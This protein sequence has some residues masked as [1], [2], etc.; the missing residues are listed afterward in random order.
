METGLVQIYENKGK[1][2]F[3]REYID[4]EK[5]REFTTL[6]GSKTDD[7]LQLV[8]AKDLKRYKDGKKA[9]RKFLKGDITAFSAMIENQVR[10][11]NRDIK[12][13]QNLITP[14]ENIMLV[15]NGKRFTLTEKNLKGGV[16]EALKNL[17]FSGS[18]VQEGKEKSDAIEVEI[19]NGIANGSIEILERPTK[20]YD[21]KNAGFFKYLNTTD[22]DLTRYQIIKNETEKEHIQ[23]HCLIHTLLLCGIPQDICNAIML[24]FNS[25]YDFPKSKLLKVTE[26]IK[27]NIHLYQARDEQDKK[28]N[29]FSDS[30]YGKYDNEIKI[31]IYQKHYFI[32]EEVDYSIFSIKNYK[33]VKNERFFNK[34]TSKRTPQTYKREKYNKINS[35]QLIY[36]LFQDGNF[37]QDNIIKLIDPREKQIYLSNIET[38]QTEFELKENKENIIPVIFYADTETDVSDGLHKLLYFGIVDEY[39]NEPLIITENYTDQIYKYINKKLS[40]LPKINGKYYPKI[41]FHNVKYDFNVIKNYFTIASIVKKAGVIYSFD[42]PTGLKNKKYIHNLICIMDSYK[43]A[44]FPLRKFNNVFGL[45]KELDKKEAINYLYYTSQ[46]KYNNNENINI[47]MDGLKSDDK[48]FFINNLKT[49]YDFEYNEEKQTFNPLKYY[50][51]YLKYDVLVLRAGLQVLKNKMN[52]LTGLNINN[53]LTVSSLVD[54]TLKNKDCYNNVY[55]VK[56]NLREFIGKAVFGGRVAVNQK[57]VKQELKKII[58]DY[59]AVSLYPSAMVRMSKEMGIPTG[60]ASIIT[61][62]E[63]NEIKNYLYY[64]VQVKITKINK[65]QQ[66]PFIGHKSDGVTN[67]IND[68]GEGIDMVIDKITLE[69]YIK[70]HEIEFE[71][72]GGVYWNNGTNKQIGIVIEELFNDRNKYKKLMKKYDNETAEYKSADVMQQL[73]KLMLNSAYGK[74]IIKK[75]EIKIQIKQTRTDEEKQEYNNYVYNN[76]NTIKET[77]DLNGKS[78]IIKQYAYDD[79]SNYAHV[80]CLILSYS[81]RIM[82]EVMAIAN[83]NDINIYYQDTDS[84][85]LDNKDIP[86]L[87]KLYYEKYNRVIRGDALG[88]FHSDFSIKGASKTADIL[89]TTSI[90]LGKKCYLDILESVNDTGDKIYDSHIRLKGISTAGIDREINILMDEHQ[91]NKID[92]TIMLFNKM[93]NGETVKFILNPIGEKPMFIYTNDGVKTRQEFTR[94]ISF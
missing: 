48:K 24:N 60:K 17:F 45:P 61:C 78:Q 89:A 32:Y 94:N 66:I 63:Y 28:I 18:Y 20:K 2:N 46:T 51:Y 19:R 15:L 4:G 79:S 92:A 76:F 59:D 75:E 6:K 52:D 39:D 81:K 74:T 41:Y 57:Y 9:R 40:S 3:Y 10:L 86:K 77:Y 72:I 22:I 93:K 54:K 53:V 62:T 38:E 70:F 14:T 33:E 42:I 1:Y 26:L 5:K 25:A 84:M 34:I 49:I 8:V 55:S 90:F 27:C 23:V 50:L 69:D 21:N 88:Q 71:I 67:Y 43:M 68:V 65:S 56:G 87:E 64:I 12:V 31:A 13:L 36:Y 83:D 85:H 35:L 44:P 58:N 82:N 80:G 7:R 73:I 30:V 16:A 11:K 47:Y 91:I 37:K 29:I